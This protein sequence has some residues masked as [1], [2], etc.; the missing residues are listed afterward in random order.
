MN[1]ANL[2]FATEQARQLVIRRGALTLVLDPIEI[3]LGDRQ[4]KLSPLES[5]LMLVLMRRGRATWDELEQALLKSNSS[6]RVRD[7][8]VHRIR[9][10]FRAAGA[11]NPLV[12]V[13]GWGLKLRVPPDARNSTSLWIGERLPA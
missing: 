6:A 12:T 4:I 9:K 1:L 10:K 2:A 11:E 3:W 8:V 7:V 13:R 5:A